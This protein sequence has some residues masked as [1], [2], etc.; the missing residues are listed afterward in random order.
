MNIAFRPLTAADLPMLLDWLQRPHVKDWWDDGDDTLDKVRR[1]YTADRGEV[2]RFILLLAEDERALEPAG[3]FQYWLGE[4]FT[5]G[6]DQFLAE[7]A[8]L[9][10]GIGTQA[11]RAFVELVNRDQ[12]PDTVTVDPNPA[13]RRAIRCYEKA[14]FRPTG[15]TVNDEGEPAYMMRLTPTAVP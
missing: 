6:I 1:R 14:G 13:N 15:E 5:V 3:Y 12:A 10:R 11:V 9:N 7:S 4:P 8:L 2:K